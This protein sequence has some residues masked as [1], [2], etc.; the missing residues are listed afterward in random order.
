MKKIA[1]PV[2]FFILLLLSFRISTLVNPIPFKINI[3]AEATPDSDLIGTLEMGDEVNVLDCRDGWAVIRYKGQA[4]FVYRKELLV[5][6][7]KLFAFSIPVNLSYSQSPDFIFGKEFYLS[8]FSM[9]KIILQIFIL[10]FL[11]FMIFNP[12][13]RA[14]NKKIKSAV[15]Q[16]DLAAKIRTQPTAD[17]DDRRV[18]PTEN[19]S[20]SDDNSNRELLKD[21][22]EV[23]DNLKRAIKASRESKD[24]DS[25]LQG[26][27]MIEEYL[28]GMLEKKW[29]LI[30]M[31]CEGK[32]F[33]PN[34]HEALTAE[35]RNDVTEIIV[36]EDVQSGYTLHGKVLKHAKVKVAKPASKKQ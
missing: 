14:K 21:L 1:I 35:E 12:V 36:L 20:M 3:R 24:F 29:G 16:R 15:H 9:S 13:R 22:T 4:C 28:A 8:H 11:F 23:L 6:S 7:I 19:E 34:L 2:L 31:V 26:V 10:F 30:R 27:S 18:K 32:V 5:S 25:L 17:I 33:D